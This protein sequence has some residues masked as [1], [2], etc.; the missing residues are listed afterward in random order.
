LSKEVQK[1]LKNIKE[2]IPK[3]VDIEITSDQS[4]F[5]KESLLNVYSNGLQGIL[6]YFFMKSFIASTI[7]NIAISVAL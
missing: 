2:K 4:E 5:I 7:I 1:K 6:F 3:D